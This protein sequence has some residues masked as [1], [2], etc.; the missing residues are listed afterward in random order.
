MSIN[1]SNTYMSINNSN[2]HFFYKKLKL[3]VL[4]CLIIFYYTIVQAHRTVHHLDHQLDNPPQLDHGHFHKMR[5]LLRHA[6][7]RTRLYAGCHRDDTPRH[8][9]DYA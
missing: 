2:I 7:V 6:R 4:K 1:N 3:Q 9:Q 5:P 8:L